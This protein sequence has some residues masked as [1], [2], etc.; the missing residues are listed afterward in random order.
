MI[1]NSFTASLLSSTTRTRRPV[2]TA[3]GIIVFATS[4]AVSICATGSRTVKVLPATLLSLVAVI[5][6][7][8]SSTYDLTSDRPMPRPLYPHD[9]PLSTC[10]NISKT[11]ANWSETIPMPESFTA[12]IRLLPLR[13]ELISIFPPR[14]V[15]FVASPM[16]VANNC[17][18]RWESPWTQVG[19]AGRFTVSSR[20]ASSIYGRHVSIAEVIASVRLTDSQRSLSL[21]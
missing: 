16:M 7:P 17:D 8:C 15:Y 21:P 5:A 9:S 13:C 10:A 12:T 4:D 3:D 1:A 6:P 11:Q 2:G 19:C 14:G 20:Q 18:R